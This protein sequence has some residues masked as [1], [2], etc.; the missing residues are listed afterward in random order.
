L[1]LFISHF[2]PLDHSRCRTVSAPRVQLCSRIFSTG[3]C[4]RNR[5]S[6]TL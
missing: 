4:T 5:S 3:A 1:V 2:G 6:R